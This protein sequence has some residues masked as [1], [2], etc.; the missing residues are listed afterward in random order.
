ML[1][2]PVL[3]TIFSTIMRRLREPG[4]AISLVTSYDV[5]ERVWNP[6]MPPLFQP[7]IGTEHRAFTPAALRKLLINSLA[8]TGLTDAT[9]N[10]LIFPP[11]DVRRS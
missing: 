8:A 9:G 3:A 1:V 5:H 7:D 6:P 11:H 2:S 4:E 10:P